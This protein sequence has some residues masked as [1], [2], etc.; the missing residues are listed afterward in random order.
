[1]YLIFWL[2]IY[3]AKNIFLGKT[4]R[5]LRYYQKH[6]Q[7]QSRWVKYLHLSYYQLLLVYLI[8][9][10]LKKLYNYNE[11]N[12]ERLI[13]CWSEFFQKY[14]LT[15]IITLNYISI[16]ICYKYNFTRWYCNIL[17]VSSDFCY[18]FFV[19]TPLWDIFKQSCIL[20]QGLMLNY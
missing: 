10:K 7:K 20:C 3:L 6:L 19:V 1:M 11:R 5:A 18:W 12:Y 15:I 8:L 17:C 4:K 13:V 16:I 14:L 2:I 9:F